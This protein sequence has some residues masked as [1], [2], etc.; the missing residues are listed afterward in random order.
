MIHAPP[1]G[2]LIDRLADLGRQVFREA[3]L[4]GLTDL[5]VHSARLMLGS[6][7]SLGGLYSGLLQ[8]LLD[9]VGEAWRTKEFR[10]ADEHRSALT[11]RRVIERLSAGEPYRDQVRGTILLLPAPHEQHIL[12]LMMVEHALRDAG[13]QVERPDAMPL[14]E[15]P[16]YASGIEDLALIGFSLHAAPAG[17]PLRRELAAMRREL[18]EVP[19]LLGGLAVRRHPELAE[20]IG[21]DQVAG[22]VDSAVHV[23]AELTNPL[24]VRERD[25]LRLVSVGRTNETIAAELGIQ[26]PT[27]KTHLERIYT[28]LGVRDR[29]ASA[30]EA[31]RRGWIT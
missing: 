8:P 28:K 24:T 18:P 22:D 17:H 23:A 15:V 19:V 14:P 3:V 12:G 9:E 31:I 1:S 30:S 6:G 2:D 16:A 10:V 4:A 21:A 11:A 25:V 27:V 26:V 13:W 5:A 29:A 7:L 20:R